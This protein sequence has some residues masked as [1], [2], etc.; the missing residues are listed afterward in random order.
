MKVDQNFLQV[1]KR[2][3]A[4]KIFQVYCTNFHRITTE[5]ICTYLQS[6]NI[7]C[8]NYNIESHFA[9]HEIQLQEIRSHTEKFRG[10]LE[11]KVRTEELVLAI[12]LRSIPLFPNDWQITLAIFGADRWESTRKLHYVPPL[13]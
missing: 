1:D 12:R 8:P 7:S 9:F 5:F 10:G 13:E 2:F 3:Q 4:V 11:G 6:L